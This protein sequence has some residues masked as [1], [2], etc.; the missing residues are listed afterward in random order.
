MVD[1]RRRVLD[2]LSLRRAVDGCRGLQVAGH[3]WDFRGNFGASHQGS[4]DDGTPSSVVGRLI[5]RVSQQ[6]LVG[7]QQPSAPPKCF[8][9]LFPH[10]DTT[11]GMVKSQLFPSGGPGVHSLSTDESL[12]TSNNQQGLPHALLQHG[13]GL[14]PN[15]SASRVGVT[16]ISH[17]SSFGSIP[18]NVRPKHCK[19]RNGSGSAIHDAGQRRVRHARIP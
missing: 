14:A 13:C 4:A 18:Q 7:V 2:L 16:P 11:G 8:I 12:L 9:L 17:I 19:T 15:C 5:I 10:G 6:A 3:Q 1:L